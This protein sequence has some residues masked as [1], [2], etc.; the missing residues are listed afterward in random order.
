MVGKV[1]TQLAGTIPAGAADEE[2][3][4]HTSTRRS[5]H[6]PGVVTVIDT[7]SV[8]KGQVSQAAQNETWSLKKEKWSCRING[9]LL[10]NPG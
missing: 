2:S 8:G 3:A 7:H 1:V 4:P 9:T 5:P 10:C 6:C